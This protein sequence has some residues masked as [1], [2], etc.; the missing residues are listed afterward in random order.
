MTEISNSRLNIR[1]SIKAEIPNG[2]PAILVWKL[3]DTVFNF[4]IEGG[5]EGVLWTDE[6]D[7]VPITDINLSRKLGYFT[8]SLFPDEPWECDPAPPLPPFS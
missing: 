5:V 3:G 2:L 1:D 7:F 8:V 6:N 4:Q